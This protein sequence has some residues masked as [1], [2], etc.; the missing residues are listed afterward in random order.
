MVDIVEIGDVNV[1]EHNWGF[2]DDYD[3]AVYVLL[4]VRD[5]DQQ[6]FYYVGESSKFEQ[7]LKKHRSIA[8]FRKV[9]EIDGV[10]YSTHSADFTFVDVIL[11]K[12]IN[13]NEHE[14]GH[15]F[16]NRIKSL[17]RETMLETAIEYDTTDVIGGR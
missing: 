14:V 10:S 11:L 1:S 15:L 3:H 6:E 7:R 4:F 12:L 13:R 16:K 5:D 17:E 9:V 2:V 8:E